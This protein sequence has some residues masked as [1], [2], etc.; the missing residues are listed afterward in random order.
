MG[1]YST[2]TIVFDAFNCKYEVLDK[3]AKEVEEKEGIQTAGNELPVLNKEF[4]QEGK[5]KE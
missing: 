4:D 2:R 1:A 5:A 3:Q